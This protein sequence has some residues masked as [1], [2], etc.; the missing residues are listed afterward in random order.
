MQ[1]LAVPKQATWSKFAPHP[2]DSSVQPIAYLKQIGV[3]FW[4]HQMER[5]VG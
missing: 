2:Q 4:A 1:A 3:I 5:M